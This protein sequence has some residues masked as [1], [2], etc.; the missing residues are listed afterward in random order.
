MAAKY[1]DEPDPAQKQEMSDF[2]YLLGRTYPCAKCGKHFLEMIAADPPDLDSQETFSLW[3]C[4][5]HNKVNSNLGKPQFPC[6]DVDSNYYCGCVVDD[7]DDTG[8][9]ENPTHTNPNNL[10]TRPQGAAS[11]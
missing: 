9:H 4:N 2:L 11:H 1:P 7:M 3:M 10:E 8:E 6:D 5:T